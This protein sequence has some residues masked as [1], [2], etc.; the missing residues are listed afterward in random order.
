[1]AQPACEETQTVTRSPV[2]EAR[3]HGLPLLY[4]NHV[5]GHDQLVYDGASF[6]VEADGRV[7]FEA[8]RFEPEVPFDLLVAVPVGVLVAGTLAV[9]FAHIVP[10]MA[11]LVL[12]TVVFFTIARTGM[13]LSQREAWL[14]LGAYG[15]A[16]YAVWTVRP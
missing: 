16:L 13:L 10:M 3:R 2:P 15:G 8:R 1:M 4:V 6:A 12:A 14:L 5:G 11:F 7:V 9:T